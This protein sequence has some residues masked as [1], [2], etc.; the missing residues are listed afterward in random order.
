MYSI[1]FARSVNSGLIK[2]GRTQQ[3]ESRLALL[4]RPCNGGRVELLAVVE[5]KFEDAEQV[6]HKMFRAFLAKGREWFSIGEDE[7]REAIRR[8][9]E[10]KR[11]LLIDYR[12]GIQQSPSVTYMRQPLPPR[13]KTA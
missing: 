9:D 7:V 2:I 12:R 13:R 11:E 6:F 4:G 10:D 8:W 3:L 1:Y 5:T